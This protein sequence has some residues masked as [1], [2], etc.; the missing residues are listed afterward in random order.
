M[1]SFLFMARRG[2]EFEVAGHWPDDGGLEGHQFFCHADCFT[3]RIDP[4]VRTTVFDL[5]L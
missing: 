2:G 5:D 3:A 1:S 4:T